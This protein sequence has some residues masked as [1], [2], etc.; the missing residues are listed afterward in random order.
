MV[1]SASDEWSTALAGAGRLD[2]RAGWAFALSR[3][4]AA[5][6]GDR[7]ISSARFHRRAARSRLALRRG[8]A[9]CGGFGLFVASRLSRWSVICLA[10]RIPGGVVLHRRRL[11]A[12][13]P[14]ADATGSVV[15]GSKECVRA[16][17]PVRVDQEGGG[18]GD[19]LVNRR[20]NIRH[21]SLEPSVRQPA[22]GRDQT[23]GRFS[24]NASMP[25]AASSISMLPAIVSLAMSYA[26]A[27]G[28]S[29]C[30]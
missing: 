4:A 12:R 7:S 10:W 5:G 24:R 23:A 14:R 16:C 1:S 27:S 21:A 20:V 15:A 25:S 9:G 11:H 6:R 8:R 22:V 13:R 2:R 19:A 17:A 30:V 26:S 28:R 3:P 18:I 29:I